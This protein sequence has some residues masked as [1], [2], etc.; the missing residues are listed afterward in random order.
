M[1]TDRRRVEGAKAGAADLAGSKAATGMQ[2]GATAKAA[3]L[4]VQIGPSHE[5]LPE[6]HP[7]Y[8]LVGRVASEWSHLEHILDAIIW[9][10]A[11]IPPNVSAC[12]TAQILGAYPRFLTIIALGTMRGLSPTTLDRIKSVQGAVSRAQEE[13][14]RA[15]H[16]PWYIEVGS[17]QPAQFKS[18]PKSALVYGYQDID[19]QAIKQTIETIKQRA[20]D[21]ASLRQLISAELATL[22]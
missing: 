10:L 22:P 7:L 15:I 17:G 4:V 21:A 5:P 13:R 14:N 8:A 9:E 2:A 12:I 16:D 6:L 19:E 18:M 20:A 11:R 3:E 1:A